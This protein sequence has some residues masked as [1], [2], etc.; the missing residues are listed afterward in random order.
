MNINSPILF[1]LFFKKNKENSHPFEAL[2]DGIISHPDHQFMCCS[3]I[4]D[5]K[6]EDFCH[7]F[8]LIGRG[9]MTR[10]PSTLTYASIVSKD[11]ICMVLLLA[12]QNDNKI[13][14]TVDL[15]TYITM[16]CQENIWAAL[17]KDFE[18]DCTRKS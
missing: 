8:W 11:T 1:L 15:N 4:F 16:P 6:M 17:R 18:A 12:A 5:V 14:S 2:Q 7:K 9:H 3:I 10:A 13:W